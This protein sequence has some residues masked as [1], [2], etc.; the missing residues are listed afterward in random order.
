MLYKHVHL[1]RPHTSYLSCV[2]AGDEIE[3]VFKDSDWWFGV[4]KGKKVVSRKAGC[5]PMRKHTFILSGMVLTFVRR[6]YLGRGASHSHWAP[7]TYLRGE[8]SYYDSR[9]IF[10]AHSMAGLMYHH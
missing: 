4:C 7:Q 5:Y 8:V 6:D 3:V 9:F 10:R 1:Q 2:R